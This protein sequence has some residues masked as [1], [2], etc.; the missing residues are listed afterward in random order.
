MANV[1]LVFCLEDLLSLF[2]QI[3]SLE[4]LFLSFYL[5]LSAEYISE[6]ALKINVQWISSLTKWGWKK[7]EDRL[8]LIEQICWSIMSRNYSLRLQLKVLPNKDRSYNF[9]EPISTVQPFVHL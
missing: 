9:P 7:S 3:I 8:F 2:M 1:Y 4:L 6:Q 5:S